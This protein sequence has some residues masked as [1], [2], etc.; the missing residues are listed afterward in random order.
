VL[1]AFAN[2]R[3]LFVLLISLVFDWPSSHKSPF[4]R[5]QTSRL[6]LPRKRCA[7]VRRKLFRASFAQY[8]RSLQISPHKVDHV[9]CEFV[10]L[11][12]WLVGREQVQ[13]Y[14]V[15]GHFRHKTVDPASSRSHC[16][17]GNCSSLTMDRLMVE[18]GLWREI[19]GFAKATRVATDLMLQFPVAASQASSFSIA[20]GAAMKHSLPACSR[21]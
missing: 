10:R 12:Y 11:R 7:S 1:D 15:F 4:P 13:A 19:C 20:A 6:L 9:L 8:V 16:A 14:V 2:A 3:V 5:S 18:A 21:P 17:R